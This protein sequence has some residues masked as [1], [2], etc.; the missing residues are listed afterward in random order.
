MFSIINLENKLSEKYFFIIL[1][2]GVNGVGKIIFIGKIVNFLKL[3]GKK[4]LIAAVDIFRAAAVEQF[5]IWVKR[6]GCDIIKYVEGSD[7]AV[8]V[9]D[10]IQV[11]RVRKVDVLIVDM[12]GR[13]YI[14][15]N[16]IEE[17][18]KIDW[19]IN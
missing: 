13:F 17:F 4:V 15:K 9:F 1:M 11:M 5:E 16:L 6:V 7:L 18:K 8:V 3:N 14:K 10:G 2:V 12:V 19:V